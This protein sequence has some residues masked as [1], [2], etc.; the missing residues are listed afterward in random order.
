MKKFLVMLMFVISVVGFGEEIVAAFGRDNYSE[1]DIRPGV[2]IIYDDLRDR[3]TVL[4]WDGVVPPKTF[5][6]GDPFFA[7]EMMKTEY[8][9]KKSFAYLKYKGKTYKKITKGELMQLLNQIGFYE[10][11]R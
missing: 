11:E 9:G 7:P 3:Y 5:S 2:A 6:I 1:T 10:T 4:R 8:Y